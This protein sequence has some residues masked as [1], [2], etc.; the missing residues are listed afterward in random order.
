L[1]FKYQNGVAGFCKS[2]RSAG[3][4]GLIVPDIPIEDPHAEYWEVA[5]QNRLFPVPLVSPVSNEPRML[6]IAT[7]TRGGFVYC[8]STTG[9]TGARKQL[10]PSLVEYLQRVKSTINLPRAVGFGIST[11]EH[12]RTLSTFAEIAVVGSATIDLVR[13]TPKR[14]RLKSVGRFVEKLATR[15]RR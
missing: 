2:A 7:K 12:I 15:P 11:P 1:L 5:R 4:Q 14:E 8:V 10:N 6:H 3:I 9:V 13:K